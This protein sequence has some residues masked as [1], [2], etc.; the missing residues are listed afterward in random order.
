M[1]RMPGRRA[2]PVPWSCAAPRAAPLAVLVVVSLVA[3]A[4]GA[5]AGEP[6]AGKGSADGTA[7]VV[8]TA[9]PPEVPLAG[10]IFNFT[11][12]LAA[13]L[14]S[15]IRA[16]RPSAGFRRWLLVEKGKR[17]LTVMAGTDAVARYRIDLGFQPIGDKGAEGDGRTPE[18]T[19][20][21]CTKLGRSR[22]HRFIG[23]S[24]PGPKD[25]ERGRREGRVSAAEQ[26][27]IV[28]ANQRRAAPPWR[29][30][31]GGAVGIHGGAQRRVIGD[32]VLGVDW[33]HGCI[34]VTDAEIEGIF[35]FVQP[36][37]E[38]EIRP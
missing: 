3:A 36:G 21:V 20:R 6:V 37:T 34:A 18:G 32:R 25:A 19:Y 2:R 14:A 23:L 22:F 4:P 28:G 12:D 11:D 26:A 27:A 29:T 7:P 33:T 1:L 31:L 17:W 10:Q 9:R 16:R 5:Q 35:D 24:Y 38:V 8:R 13:R 15:W 30:A